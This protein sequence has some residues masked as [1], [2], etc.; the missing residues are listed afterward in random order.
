MLDSNVVVSVSV[1]VDAMAVVVV[2]TEARALCYCSHSNQLLDTCC[3]LV[4]AF[5]V[6]VI[7]DFPPPALTIVVETVVMIVEL[8]VVNTTVFDLPYEVVHVFHWKQTM[9]GSALISNM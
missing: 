9:D 2:V 3:I 6:M 8:V 7:V 4:T 5:G 1:C